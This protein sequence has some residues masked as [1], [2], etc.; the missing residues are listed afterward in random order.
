M[1][2]MAKM[3]SV[4]ADR[5]SD[6]FV[7]CV[8]G[9]RDSVFA[10]DDLAE[11]LRATA[12]LLAIGGA[13]RVGQRVNRQLSG[14]NRACGGAKLENALCPERLVAEHRDGDRSKTRA[15]RSGG[16]AGAALMHGSGH[17]RKQ[18]V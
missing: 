11:R 7:K 3:R 6:M 5:H 15:Q 18:P 1:T 14:W 16:H 9:T 2:A 13:N 17:L 10:A 8:D 4:L 12:H